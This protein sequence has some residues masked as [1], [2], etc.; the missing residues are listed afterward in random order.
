[1]KV[2]FTTDISSYGNDCYI[3]MAVSLV[4]CFGMYAIVV[5]EKVNGWSPSNKIY[6]LQETTCDFD[7]AKAMFKEVGGKFA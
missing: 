4:E 3:N 6:S 2:L 7:R 1:M 5:A